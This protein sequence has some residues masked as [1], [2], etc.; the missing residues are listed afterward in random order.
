MRTFNVGNKHH[1]C[2]PSWLSNGFQQSKYVL[3]YLIDKKT[4][5]ILRL[6]TKNFFLSNYSS[7]FCIVYVYNFL[8]RDYFFSCQNLFRNLLSKLTL[9]IKKLLI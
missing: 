5:I 4:L 1:T 9:N 6:Q 8:L 2:A 3:F 7:F